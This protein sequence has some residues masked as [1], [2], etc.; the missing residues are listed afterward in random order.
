MTKTACR[1]L[2]ALWIGGLALMSPPA[3]LA[4]VTGSILG[5]VTD[6][7]SAFVTGARIDRAE[8]RGQGQP[9]ELL[10]LG[11]DRPLRGCAEPLVPVHR[12]RMPLR[13]VGYP[14]HRLAGRPYPRGPR[15]STGLHVPAR[16]PART[17]RR[18]RAIGDSEQ[19]PGR[20]RLPR[21]ERSRHAHTDGAQRAR[22]GPVDRRRARQ[23]P[24]HGRRAGRRALPVWLAPPGTRQETVP[25]VDR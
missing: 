15:D 7:S 20:R 12:E 6:P 5:T 14:G 4:D 2:F 11:P 17:R 1:Y 25:L 18:Q 19:Q 8:S 9:R 3:L 13:R 10:V 24:A 23:L 22:R 16:G 21:R